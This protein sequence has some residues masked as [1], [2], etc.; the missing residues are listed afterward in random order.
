MASDSPGSTRNRGASRRRSSGSATHSFHI[1]IR[2]PGRPTRRAFRCVAACISTVRPRTVP[3]NSIASTCPATSCSS[4]RLLIRGPSP[5]SGS[6]SPR[7]WVD[8]FTGE[9]H[10]GPRVE[11]V[12]APLER[13]PVY[14]SA[15][16]IVP[17]QPYL[18]FVGQRPVGPLRIKVATGADGTFE[19]YN[20]TGTGSDFQAGD[21]V[22]A[23]IPYT[24]RLI[25]RQGTRA[26]SLPS[27]LASRGEFPR[28]VG[29]A[30][31]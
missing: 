28:A 9:T 12:T 31:L 27:R 25:R 24:N 2:S 8:F 1:C 4:P 17:L 21:Y 6:G 29:R 20:D 26:V 23:P 30:W 19:L 13:I 22:L 5:A 16:G 15:G 14:L 7:E 3:T 10:E 18:D 11:T